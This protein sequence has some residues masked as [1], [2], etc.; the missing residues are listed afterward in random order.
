VKG[1]D[2]QVLGI[3]ILT[4]GVITV[5]ISILSVSSIKDIPPKPASAKYRIGYINLHRSVVDSSTIERL[6]TF[7]C[8]IWLF[9]EWN[10]D[11]WPK[12]ENLWGDFAIQY[13]Q[14]DSFT[15]GFL[16]LS[17]ENLALEASSYDLENAPYACDYAPVSIEVED[18]HL[19]FLHAPPPVP[20]CDFQTGKYIRDALSDR[21]PFPKQLLI[22][23]FNV[24]P[25]STSYRFIRGLGYH[26][27][28]AGTPW[29]EGTFGVKPG[30]PKLFRIDYCFYG[31]RIK[32]MPA[33][34]FT[35]PGSDHAG[36]IVDV[37][38]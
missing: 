28:F 36:L 37:G 23:D 21:D 5:I 31:E 33:G 11:N 13:N 29:W 27:S 10:G 9:A 12:S 16:V 22:G 8:D 34:R 25:G 4:F 15:Y 18:L 3:T 32:V 17:T 26:D 38:W 19:T 35:I 20:G 2:K 24:L 7:D 14:S 1:R 6:Q 30:W